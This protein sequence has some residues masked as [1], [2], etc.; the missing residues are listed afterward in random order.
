MTVKRTGSTKMQAGTLGGQK[1]QA[2]ALLL[3]KGP[4]RQKSLLT[5]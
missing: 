5:C 2:A 4:G 3:A 1:L